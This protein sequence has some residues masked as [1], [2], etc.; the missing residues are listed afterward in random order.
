MY[1]PEITLATV[2][3]A[4]GIDGINPCALTV[5]LLFVTT[6]LSTLKARESNLHSAHARIVGMGSTYIGVV[7]V[8]YLALGVGLLQVAL[9]FTRQHFPAR[10]GAVVAVLM[11]L[12]MLKEYFLPNVGLRLR[13]LGT[14]RR[15]APARRQR[16]RLFQPL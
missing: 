5:L 7:F 3:V 9:I 1:L 12:W 10:V 13:A 4:G 16:K 8:T 2:V 11:G 6:L 15:V 14:I